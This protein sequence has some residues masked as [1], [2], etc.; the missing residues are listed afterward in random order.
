MGFLKSIGNAISKPFSSIGNAITGQR[1]MRRLQREA[2]A[3]AAAE[4]DN[5]ILTPEGA[6]PTTQTT[7]L[8]EQNEQDVQ[9][10]KRKRVGISTLTSRGLTRALGGDS[11]LG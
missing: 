8:D 7:L 5:P 4:A 6:A 9:G 2:D 1:S 10:R 11:T 3:R